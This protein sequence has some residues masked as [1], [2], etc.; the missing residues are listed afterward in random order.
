MISPAGKKLSVNPQRKYEKT[1]AAR[2]REAVIKVAREQKSAE[3]VVGILPMLKISTIC[4]DPFT[5]S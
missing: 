2:Y 3:Y 5:I 4:V 1:I